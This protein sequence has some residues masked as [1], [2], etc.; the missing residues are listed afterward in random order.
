MFAIDT[1]F[2]PASFSAS[3]I[4]ITLL[5]ASNSSIRAGSPSII[6]HPRTR[7]V[8]RK[9]V[10]IKVDLLAALLQHTDHV[11]ERAETIGVRRATCMRLVERDHGVVA[12]ASLAYYH[13]IEIRKGTRHMNCIERGT[14]TINRICL[15]GCIALQVRTCAVKCVANG[16]SLLAT[17]ELRF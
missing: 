17:N 12:V 16:T 8:I 13:N 1:C 5:N 4:H 6:V 11:V 2:R 7:C 9:A 15:V 10:V 14:N 3:Y